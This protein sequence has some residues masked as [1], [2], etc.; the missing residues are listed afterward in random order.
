MRVP[1]D[2][3]AAAALAALFCF[4]GLGNHPLRAADEPRVAGIAWEMQ[5]TGSIVPQLGGEPFLE[6]PPLYYALLGWFIEHLG[7]REAVARLPGAIASALTLLVV[8]GLGR[9][10]ASPSAGLAGLLALVGIA[11]F[12]RYSHRTLVDPLLMLFVAAGQAAYVCAAWPRSPSQPEAREPRVGFRPL[13]A[14]YL[15]AGL[16][17]WVKGPIGVVAIAGPIV[18]DVLLGR[19]WR[20]LRSPAHALGLPLLLLACAAWPLLLQRELGEAGVQAFLVQNGLYRVFPG[21][22]SY[23]GGHEE[24]LWFYFERA[25]VKLGFALALVPA[26]GPWLVRGK[27]PPGWQLGPLRFL[28]AVAPVGLLL[29]TLPGTKRVLY[30]LPFMPALAVALGAWIDAAGRDD[31]ERGRVEAAVASLCA[32]VSALVLWPFARFAIPRQELRDDIA[33]ARSQACRGPL[34]AT[35]IAYAVSVLSFLLIIPHTNGGRDMGPVAR[36]VGE[37]A[38]GAPLAGYSLD[39]GMRGALSFYAGRQA[40][41]LPG[42]DGLAG[43]LARGGYRY[44]FSPLSFGA[45]IEQ[46]IGVPPIRAWPDDERTYAL[47]AFDPDARATSGAAGLELTSADDPP[48]AATAPGAPLR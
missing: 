26:L 9:R 5:H 16:A 32:R 10:L 24:P 19:R 15:C 34:R 47:F 43:R 7:N 36:E 23:H 39:E 6:H 22:Q 20:L 31:P 12:F 2:W 30:M 27:L 4:T 25:P 29:L 48:S 18:V 28:A 13:L 46:E 11:F 38:A 21:A 41:P 8:F 33:R 44:L 42:P 40:E 3:L 14:V 37:R 1:R 17:F 35:A 45:E